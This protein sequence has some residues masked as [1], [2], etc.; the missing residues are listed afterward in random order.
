MTSAFPDANTESG[1]QVVT[2]SSP[3]DRDCNVARQGLQA[4]RQP[5]MCW[6]VSDRLPVIDL[7]LAVTDGV[8]NGFA[9]PLAGCAE[10]APTDLL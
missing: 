7:E 9:S 1:A 10:S 8:G 3:D 6:P 4:H 5:G 2:R